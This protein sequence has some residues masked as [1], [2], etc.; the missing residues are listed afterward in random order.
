MVLCMKHIFLFLIKLKIVFYL[1][2]KQNDQRN[3][4]EKSVYVS[5]KYGQNTVIS[6][7]TKTKFVFDIFLKNEWDQYAISSMKAFFSCTGMA[8]SLLLKKKLFWVQSVF[9][10]FHRKLQLYPK[11]FF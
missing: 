10:Y 4:N 8:I 6:F 7:H 11:N 9:L 3:D 5:L 2:C 1:H